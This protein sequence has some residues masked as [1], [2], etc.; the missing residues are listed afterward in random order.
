M[1][2]ENK[3]YEYDFSY[4]EIMQTRYLKKH[5]FILIHTVVK[6]GVVIKFKVLKPKISVVCK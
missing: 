5:R 2:L 4:L 6:Q 3:T 1:F